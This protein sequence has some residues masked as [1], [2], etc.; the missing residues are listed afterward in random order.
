MC[1]WS[2]LV[3]QRHDPCR[4]NELHH[5]G[6]GGHGCPAI[7]P[8]M[9]ARVLQ[10][11]Q[12]AGEERT[13]KQHRQSKFLEEVQREGVLCGSVEAESLLNY[14]GGVNA[15]W[16]AEQGI[17]Q[18]QDANVEQ[19]VHQRS[20]APPS[21]Y[22][23]QIAE[24]A[25]KPE[26]Q[27]CN[28]HKGAFRDTETCVHSRVVLRVV[29]LLRWVYSFQFRRQ[30][31]PESADVQQLGN[32]VQGELYHEGSENY[33]GKAVYRHVSVTSSCAVQAENV[34]HLTWLF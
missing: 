10:E 32:E 27:Q 15:E 21:D 13:T 18:R 30:L 26:G 31:Q 11:Q 1:H 5:Q 22:L 14:E 2:E 16:Q 9:C 3:E 19:A 17:G 29:V 24:A 7:E 28:Q 6:V 8:G 12:E 33:Y 23:V 20:E 25:G 4:G 34:S